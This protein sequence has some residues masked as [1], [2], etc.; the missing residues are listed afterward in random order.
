MALHQ[1]LRF[2]CEVPP[3]GRIELD[4]PLPAGSHVTVYIVDESGERDL[5]S[6][7]ATSTTFWD[8]SE[9]DEDWNDA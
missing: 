6:A 5:L 3:N 9:D 8:N 1:P 2:D 7:A 4:V